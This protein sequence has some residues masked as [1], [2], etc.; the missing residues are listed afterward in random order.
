[1]TN[2]QAGSQPEPASS[3]KS[4]L[5]W[6]VQ[7]GLGVAGLAVP[8]WAIVT[9]WGGIAHSHPAYGILLAVTGIAAAIGLTLALWRRAQPRSTGWRRVLLIVGAIAAIGWL[10]TLAWARPHSATEPAISAMASDDQVAVEESAT[11]IVMTPST[12][13]GASAVFFQPGALVD[14]RAYAVTLR[15]LAEA[16]VPV[17]IVKQP[18]GIAFLAVGAFDQVRADFPDVEQWVIAGHSLGGTVASM[19]ADDADG[20]GAVAGLMLWASY[21]ANDISTSLTVPVLSLSGSQDGL[22]TPAK[23]QKYVPLLPADTKYLEIDGMC[24]AQFGAYGAQPGDGTPT[25]PD[26]QAH[27][28]VSSAALDFVDSLGD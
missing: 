15:P 16:G 24:H 23:I 3:R 27:E 9:E 28:M 10:G 5:G 6:W 20:S 1:M 8:I 26:Q 4:S 11:R 18:I 19:E 21:P 2:P 7:V 12:T 14:P 13:S 22:A 25:I 17:V